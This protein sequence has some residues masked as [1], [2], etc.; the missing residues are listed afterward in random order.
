M[1]L[2]RY[3]LVALMIALLG[4]MLTALGV[5]AATGTAAAAATATPTP[6][7]P[8]L[9]VSS[10]IAAIRSGPGPG[11][12]VIGMAGRG[13]Q[14]PIIGRIPQVPWWQVSFYGRPGWIAATDAT[15][16]AEAMKVPVVKVLAAAPTPRP[17]AAPPTKEALKVAA[18]AVTVTATPTATPSLLPP[19]QDSVTLSSDTTF[20]VRAR[21]F[22]GWGYEIV[23]ASK[24]YD[25]EMER[26]IY[27]WVAHQIWADSLFARHPE[28][29]RLTI[30]DA[31]MPAECRVP[32]A[33]L[34][35]AYGES[36]CATHGLATGFG[37]GEGAWVNVGCAQDD[38]HSRAYVQTDPEEC[39]VAIKS[40]GPHLSDLVVSGAIMAYGSVL[41]WNDSPPV[42]SQSPYTPDLGRA[43][44]DPDTGQ[45]RWDDPFIKTVLAPGV[46]LPVA[47]IAAQQTQHAP[48]EPPSGH[49]AFTE[50]RGNETD[51]SVLD[52][53]TSKMWVAATNARQPDVRGDGRIVFNGMGGGREDLFTVGTDGND[54]IHIG[55]HPEDSYP[56]WSPSGASV[57][58]YSG[59]AG[60]ADRIFIQWDASH[61]EEPMH[62]QVD[63]GSKL[64]PVYGRF[65]V[66]IDNRIAFSGC[67]SWKQGSNCGIWT[68]EVSG[69]QPRPGTQVTKNEGDRPTDSFNGMLLYA[70][71]VTGNWDIYAIPLDGGKPRNLT[72]NPSQDVGATFSPDGSYIA[73]MSDRG[74]SWGIWVMDAAGGG[75]KLLV[76]V[77]AGF[78][79][80][81][82]SERLAWGP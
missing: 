44:R 82:D 62:L 72:S 10:A 47:V 26:D 39:F 6:S 35:L 20:P 22:K 68:L 58:F 45:W 4:V 77:P 41:G 33:P 9:T 79:K 16:P 18:A 23:D 21:S 38:P 29:I 13:I 17:T 1:S 61:S 80:D 66:W 81:W 60:G 24:T 12:R 65:P 36:L 32:V 75:Q 15:V 69:I 74:G 34:Q 50:A 70:S 59:L 71:S 53:A 54:L 55:R 51:V 48:A 49:I 64:E 46:S 67:D 19:V 40:S 63:S 31:Q 14:L 11:N 76:S 3:V 37:D 57:T 8:V 2:R 7:G 42:F 5:T 56:S 30:I 43:L 27:G 78:G 52:V 73:F 28:G 25:L